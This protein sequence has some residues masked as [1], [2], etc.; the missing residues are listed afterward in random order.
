MNPVVSAAVENEP[1]LDE[2]IVEE[3]VFARLRF[4]VDFCE[5]LTFQEDLSASVERAL[6]RTSRSESERADVTMRYLLR[7]WDRLGDEVLGQLSELVIRI[8]ERSR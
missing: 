4:A 1:T 8:P 3:L 6:S 2:R 5:L 7:A